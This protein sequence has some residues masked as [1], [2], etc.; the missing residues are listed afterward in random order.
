MMGVIEEQIA[1]LEQKQDVVLKQIRA[2]GAQARSTLNDSDR[3]RLE[4]KKSQLS[5]DYDTLRKKIERIRTGAPPELTPKTIDR[6]KAELHNEWESELHWLDYGKQENQFH[7]L[8]R[9]DGHRAVLLFI[10]DRKLMKADLYIKRIRKCILDEGHLRHFPEN[11]TVEGLVDPRRFIELW[12]DKLHTRS[13]TPGFEAAVQG[14]I[15][16]L[17]GL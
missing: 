1:D 12:Q 6:L 13:S 2:C 8:V 11:F 17:D 7:S 3:V 4:E 10:R 16:T 15:Q 14:V 9:V 5:A